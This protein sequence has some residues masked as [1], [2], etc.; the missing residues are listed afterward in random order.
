MIK[1]EYIAFRILGTALAVLLLWSCGEESIEWELKTGVP[2]LIVVEGVLTNK[3]NAHEVRISRPVADPSDTPEA[4]SHAIVAIFDGRNA[5]LLTETSPG[6]YHTE[7]YIRAV[8]NRLYTLYILYEG[9]EYSADSYLVPVQ[10]MD[11]LRY[12][13][14][15]GEQNLYELD[16]RES[17]D[18]SM[19]EITLDWSHLPAYSIF[20]EEMTKARIVYYTVKSIDVNKMF[21]PEKERVFFPAGTRV[22]RRK[23]SMSPPQEDFVRTL[24]AETE[25]RGGIFDVQ[26]GNVR[27]NLSDGAVGYFSVSTVV[28]DSTV[29]QPLY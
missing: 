26:P 28:S 9:V 21:S 17:S 25:W 12:H 11:P 22:I 6:V 20:P 2:D 24:M 10:R 3:R 16:L 5:R 27:T 7:P 15:E 14:V 29:I 18:A 1:M 4:V 23:Y 19:L 8:I 13:R